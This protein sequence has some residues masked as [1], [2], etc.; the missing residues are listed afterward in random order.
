M[1]YTG[2]DAYNVVENAAYAGVNSN[3]DVSV[4][5]GP[6]TASTT[7]IVVDEDAYFVP[8]PFTV[9]VFA[10]PYPNTTT[11]PGTTSVSVPAT[12]PAN[13]TSQAEFFVNTQNLG[14]L[15]T[16]GAID[17]AVSGTSGCT[18]PVQSSMAGPQAS[19]GSDPGLTSSTRR[20]RPPVPAS[21]M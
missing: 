21:S 8:Q 3:G 7:N 12:I 13:G 9:Q 17:Y 14:L 1:N 20:T 11:T 15:G 6:N 5:N 4:E 10:V 2:G 19:C 16:G 18:A